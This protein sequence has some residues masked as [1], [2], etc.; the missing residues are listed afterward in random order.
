M[1]AKDCHMRPS[2]LLHP[3]ARLRVK[4]FKMTQPEFAMF[5]GISASMLAQVETLKRDISI[6]RVMVI[7]KKLGV[8]WTSLYP[9]ESKPAPKELEESGTEPLNLRLFDL[10]RHQRSELHQAGLITDEEYTYLVGQGNTSVK[11]LESYDHMRAKLAE[12]ITTS[13]KLLGN[14][15]AFE[16]EAK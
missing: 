15:G 5:I 4:R 8:P 16:N 11:R 13:Q 12:I 14:I 3:I 6:R 7:S 10:V 9:R 1:T 2:A